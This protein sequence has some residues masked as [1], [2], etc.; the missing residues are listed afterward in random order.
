MEKKTELDPSFR[1]HREMVTSFR[2]AGADRIENIYAQAS[3]IQEKTA[4]NR[5]PETSSLT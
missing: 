1:L 4:A 3:R 2:V 5:L